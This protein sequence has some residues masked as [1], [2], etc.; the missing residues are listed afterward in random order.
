MR[1]WIQ[2]TEQKQ[3]IAEAQLQQD[4]QQHDQEMANENYQRDLDRINKKEIATITAESKA[5][6][7]DNNKDNVP[8]VLEVSMFQH[9]QSKSARE[10]QLKL[11]EIAT[12]NSETMKK[13]EVE[14]EKIQVARENMTNDLQIA[15]ENAKGRSR[16]K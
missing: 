2:H 7:P 13:L 15:R 16:K 12:K 8:D 3:N 5:V 4:Q 6:L 10:Y 11:A 1:I 9:E 14:R